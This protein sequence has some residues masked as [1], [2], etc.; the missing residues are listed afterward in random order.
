MKRWAVVV[1]ALYFVI[2]LALTWPVVV[3]SL[4]PEVR[5]GQIPDVFRWP[6]YWVWLAVMVCGQAVMLLVP[7]SVARERPIPRR[8]VIW[9]AL[10]SGLMMGLL[11][12]GVV[13]S[14][15]EFVAQEKALDMAFEGNAWRGV[16]V[17]SAAWA[18]WTILFYRISRGAAASDV[19]TKQCRYLLKGSILELLV[20]VPT[21]VVARYRDYCCAGVL[22]FIGIAFGLSV[23]IFSFGPGV[24]FLF[25]HRWKQLHPQVEGHG[26]QA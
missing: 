19:V 9:P 26:S 3:A 17:L 1:V 16:A 4:Y 6:Q 23:M 13:G 12:L 10:A 22:T 7:V 20:A 5:P 18:I 24:F 21:H 2:L 11:A 25:A 15:L 14:V 8:S